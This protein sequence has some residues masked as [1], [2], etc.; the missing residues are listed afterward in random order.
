LA[1]ARFSRVAGCSISSH[2]ARALGNSARPNCVLFYGHAFTLQRHTARFPVCWQA[3]VFWQSKGET[4]ILDLAGGIPAWIVA[5][6]TVL[7]GLAFGSFLNVCISR[8]PR[9]E[10]IVRPRSRCPRCGVPIGALDNIPLL[11][12][13][14]LRARCRHCHQ[15]IAW[16]YPAVELATA[17]LFLLSLLKFGLT[18]EGGGALVLSFFLLGLAVMDAETMRLPDAF[19]LPGIALGIAFAFSKPVTAMSYRLENAGFAILW[20]AV[21]AAVLLLVRGLYYFA[22]RRI[23]LGLGDVKLIAMIAA[24]LGP[25]PTLL[26]LILGCL[27]AGVFGIASVAFSRGS[28]KLSTARLPFGSFLCAA[29]LYTLFAGEP[30]IAWYLRFY[31]I[32]R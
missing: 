8:L 30:I 29:A 10:S 13:I 9:H 19:T 14:V 16:R 31:G 32:G 3:R 17:A 21:A 5:A 7:L 2:I 28:R 24:W 27:A 4:A 11:S 1:C 20:A 6:F 15:P 25:A 23:G 12:W 22:R 26:T 18:P